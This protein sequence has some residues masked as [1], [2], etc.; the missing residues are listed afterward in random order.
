MLV[1]TRRLNEAIQMGDNIRIT[2]VAIDADRVRIGIDAPKDLKIYRSELLQET[3]E[4]NQAAAASVGAM[5]LN[6]SAT[7]KKNVLEDEKKG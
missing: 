1:L 4:L 2:V 3:T 5:A 7:D 6:F